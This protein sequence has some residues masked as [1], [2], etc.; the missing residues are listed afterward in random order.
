[1][2]RQCFEMKPALIGENHFREAF[3]FCVIYRES[4]CNTCLRLKSR[5]YTNVN[6]ITITSAE[7]KV[8]RL[9]LTVLR[10]PKSSA[11]FYA[12]H[13]QQTRAK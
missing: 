11:S 8:E 1:M 2:T 10:L 6:L 3:L 5:G 4:Q 7:K 9:F 13:S 12:L